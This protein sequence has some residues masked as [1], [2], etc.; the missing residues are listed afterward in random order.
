L[1]KHAAAGKPAQKNARSLSR[2]Q[3]V[4]CLL[5]IVV[6]VV[7]YWQV[8]GCA[9]VDFDDSQYVRDNPYVNAGLKYDTICWSLRAM[10]QGTWQPV[11][12]M[13]YMVD[14]D[15]SALLFHS[16][17][18][19]P[20]VCHLTNLVVHV[21]NGLLL[22]FLLSVM[23]GSTWRSAL[24]SFLFAVHPLHVE[25]VAWIAE[26]KGLL[27]TFFGLLAMFAYLNYTRRP[28]LQRYG[29]VLLAFALA[30]MCKPMLVSLPVVLLLVDYWP[31]GRM[32]LRW[33][34][35]WEKAPLFVM[36]AASFVITFIAQRASGAVS[37]LDVLPVWCRIANAAVSYIAYVLKML[38][39]SNLAV[40][41]PVRPM[42]PLIW[43]GICSSLALVVVTILVIRT[44][45]RRP[46]LA[47]GWFWYLIT[48]VPVIG[49]VQVGAQSMAD[50]FT[51]LPLIG[52]FVVVA[53][54]IPDL[55][56][57]ISATLRRLLQASAVA[58]IVTLAVCTWSQ[59]G[60]WRDP[61]TLFDHA[62]KVTKRNWVAYD[63][64]GVAL[65]H[66]GR[67]NE[68]IRDLSKVIEIEPGY[69]EGHMN[70]AIEL[71]ASGKIDEGI[72][73]VLTALRLGPDSTKVRDEL[74]YA[75]YTQGKLDLAAEQCRAA[76]RLDPKFL[77]SHNMLGVILKARGRLDEAMSHWQ[78]AVRLDP[79][80][81]DP[82]GNLAL[83]YFSK[84]DYAAAWKQV[85][86]MKKAGGQPHQGFI[87]DLSRRMPD[88]G[89]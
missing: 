59:T 83:A 76:L 56:T 66:H 8:S 13:S 61:Y 73:H 49:L 43:Q 18:T 42:E 75:Y 82:F 79:G 29:C 4:I 36:S 44:G 39:P 52:L 72:S 30:L 21:A 38:W 51:Y 67:Y 26:R 37:N 50:R 40:L 19:D 68:G 33:R 35:V 46:Y 64:R 16:N 25:S 71:I 60:F 47:V 41:Y 65:C 87:A 62:I 23:T 22:F 6:T 48:L 32:N 11:V 9:F 78:T 70:L 20:R 3:L 69:A 34:L 53:W 89:R 55:L 88:P 1:G 5:L 85:H 57:G 15:M 63:H 10:Y 7:A 27:S 86:L 17:V 54:G 2:H 81:A 14:R 24:V 45:R 74:A 80:Y 58:L 31:L 12:W 77:S 84:G 28:N